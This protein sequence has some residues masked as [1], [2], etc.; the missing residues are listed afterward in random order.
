MAAAT[1]FLAAIARAVVVGRQDLMAMQNHPVSV[2]GASG[3]AG[4]YLLRIS[5]K[6]P[7]TTTFGRLQGGRPLPLAAGHYLYAGSARSQRGPSSLPRRLLRHACRTA[8]LPPHRIYAE[9]VATLIAADFTGAFSQQS[10]KTLHW[11]IDYLLELAEAELT[12]VYVLRHPDVRE[13]T[14]VKWLAS[15]P[16]TGTPVAG[17]G[18]SDDPGASHLFAVPAEEFWWEEFSAQL[19]T[20]F[21]DTVGAVAV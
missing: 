3:N 9:L 12:A 6:A 13:V 18:A 16:H 19:R 15:R 17:F 7:V 14:L 2:L 8:V 1:R 11:H 4:A 10:T 5:L 21:D 20:W